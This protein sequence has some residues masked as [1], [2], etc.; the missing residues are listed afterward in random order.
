[1]RSKPT[2]NDNQLKYLIKHCRLSN[3]ELA[4]KLDTTPAIIAVY[5]YRARQAGIDIPKQKNTHKSNVVKRM[6]KFANVK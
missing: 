2:L 3:P 1:M 5:K 4:E 6:K